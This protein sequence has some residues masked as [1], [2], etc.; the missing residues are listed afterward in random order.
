MRAKEQFNLAAFLPRN[1]L[2]KTIFVH[3]A[4]QV[5]EAQGASL[6]ALRAGDVTTA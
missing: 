6:M 5:T 1:K 3:Q 4:H 2:H